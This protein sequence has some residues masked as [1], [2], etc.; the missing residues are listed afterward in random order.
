MKPHQNIISCWCNCI[1]YTKSYLLFDIATDPWWQRHSYI[2]GYTTTS[3]FEIRLSSGTLYSAPISLIINYHGLLSNQEYYFCK[4]HII[5][6]LSHMVLTA[7]D[8]ININCC[9]REYA[10]C[11]TVY[12]KVQWLFKAGA[13]TKRK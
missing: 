1:L 3:Q 6:Q 10:V 7:N 5:H 9:Y 2:A 11:M 13:K 4:H 12:S 8:I